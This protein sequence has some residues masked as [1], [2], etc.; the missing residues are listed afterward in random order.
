MALAPY[1]DR[2]ALAAAQV[3]AGFD[4]EAFTEKLTSST[5]GLAL[6]DEAVDSAEG[7]A[8]AD[9]TIR[10]LARLYPRLEVT[11]PGSAAGLLSELAV[12]INPRIDLRTDATIGISVGADARRFDTT[13]FGGSREWVGY[14][15]TKGP[16]AVGS[17]ENPLGAGVAACLATGNVFRALFLSTPAPDVQAALTAYSGDRPGT[18]GDPTLTD[19]QL[20]DESVLVGLGAIGNAGA[21]ALARA[22]VKGVLH[23]V[24][25]QVVEPSN[26][27]RYVLAT[28]ADI[29]RPKVDVIAEAVEPRLQIVGHP[30]TWAQ[31]ADESSHSAHHVLVALDSARDRR[32]VQASLPRSVVNAWTQPGDL[33]V[34]SHGDF[35]TV[36]ACLFCLYVSDGPAPNEDEIVAAALGVTDRQQEVRQ[37]LYS[38]DG[39]PAALIEVVRDRL[40]IPSDVAAPFIGRP[41]RALYVEGLCGGALVPLD[42][43]GPVR[44]D[45]HVPLA[46]QSALAGVLLAAALLRQVLTGPPSTTEISR[47]DLLRRLG[48]DLRQPRLATPSCICRDTD[49]TSAYADKWT[50]SESL[51]R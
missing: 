21:W 24:D 25:H 26:L 44:Q 36:G 33:G 37:L 50:L 11:A 28:V 1:Y 19:C 46:H 51:G 16:L 38:G 29:G 48:S 10:L 6:D 13:F 12:A 43:L 7:R 23:V 31:F 15:G 4:P 20:P 2:A 3:V 32:A 5:V 42:R 35:G 34:S 9:L 18:S 45:I 8:L 14:V 47:I 30:Q 17:S 22:P 49:Y 41:I 27:Q 39:V 40:R